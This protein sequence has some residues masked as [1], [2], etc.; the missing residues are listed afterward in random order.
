MIV[1]RA[2]S[3]DAETLASVHVRSWQAAYDGI[4]PSDYLDSLNDTLDRRTSWFT[5]AIKTG[6]PLVHV[7]EH[8]EVVGFVTTGISEDGE[9]AELF[10]IYVEPDHWGHGHGH[11]LIVKAESHLKML[12]HAPAILWVL[13]GNSQA[14]HFYESHGWFESGRTALIKIGG[15]DLTEVRYERR[16]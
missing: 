4:V 9:N 11:D 15:A 16:F 5:G 3:N 8:E 14:R 2:A 13:E 7:V 12:G 6:T 10:A 1:R